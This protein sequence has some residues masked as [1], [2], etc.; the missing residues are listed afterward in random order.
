MPDDPAHSTNE[1]LPPPRSS[2]NALGASPEPQ[3]DH[4]EGDVAR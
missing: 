2:K 4:R 3:V 1:T